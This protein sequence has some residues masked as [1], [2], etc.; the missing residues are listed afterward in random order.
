MLLRV[1]GFG[2]SGFGF[3]VEGGMK[4]KAPNIQA[5]CITCTFTFGMGPALGRPA[6]A[7]SMLRQ[8]QEQT[9]GR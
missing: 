4:P 8:H 5:D 1:L 6:W 2:L 9:D 3:R 7:H